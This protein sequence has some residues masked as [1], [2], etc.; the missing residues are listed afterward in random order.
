[1][2]PKVSRLLIMDKTTGTRYLIDTE[3]DVSI[4]QPKKHR[5][6][7]GK[8][9]LYQLYAVN[10]SV[11]P[12]YG[13]VTLKPDLGLKREFPW[14]FIVADVMQPII[15]ADF[16][17]HYHLLPDMKR[18][19]LIDGKTG[20]CLQGVTTASTMQS[21]KTVIEQTAYHRILAQFP[22]IT[23]LSET[24]KRQE[25]QT[26]HYIKTTTDQPEA[27]RPRRLKQRKQNSANY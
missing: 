18:K 11:I 20:L 4:F 23:K 5:P 2:R 1:M 10:G 16:L 17:A 15:G 7:R 3:S 19:K 13:T 9:E 21:V 27:C 8:M 6:Y 26:M 25:Q 22:G 24:R 14:K 12:T